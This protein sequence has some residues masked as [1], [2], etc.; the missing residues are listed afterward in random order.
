MTTLRV[1]TTSENRWGLAIVAGLPALLVALAVPL[2][3]DGALAGFAVA[4]LVA[5]VIIAAAAFGALAGVATVVAAVGLAALAANIAGFPVVPL[6]VVTAVLSVSA[7]AA[8]ILT[9][10]RWPGAAAIPGAIVIGIALASGLAA[11]LE[12]RLIASLAAVAIVLLAFLAGPWALRDAV[13]TTRGGEATALLMLIV[14]G[15]VTYLASTALD[16]RLGTPLRL[17]WLGISDPAVT[18]DGTLPDPFFIAARWQLDPTESPRPLFTVVAGEQAPLNRPV[19]ASFPR[20]N[21]FGWFNIE[22]PGQPGDDL[23][24]PLEPDWVSGRTRVDIG[25]AL[26]GQWVPAPQQV[27]QVL[28]S[29]ATRVET[30][31][32]VITAL[33]APVSQSFGISYAVP[34]ATDEQLQQARPQVLPDIDAA[35]LLP[36]GLPDDLQRIADR[37]A[38]EAGPATWDRLLALSEFFRSPRF[39]QAPPTAL[40]AGPPDRTYA[41]VAAAINARSGLQEEYAAAWALIARSWGVPTRLVIGWLPPNQDGF[42]DADASTDGGGEPVEVIVRGGDTSVWAQARLAGLGWVSYQPSPHD[43]SANRPAV[44]RPLNPEDLP[45]PTPTPDGDDTASDG[46]GANGGGGDGGAEDNS[47]AD[48]D[49]ASPLSTLATVAVVIAGVVA[50]VLA[51]VALWM[52][53]ATRMRRRRRQRWAAQEPAESAAAAVAW[54]RGVLAEADLPLPQAWAPAPHPLDVPEHPPQIAAPV[55]DFARAAAPIRFA[56]DAVTAEQAGDLWHRVAAIE[57][58]VAQSGGRR[59][60]WRRHTHPTPRS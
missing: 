42:T 52:V 46:G 15:V 19:W 9:R 1:G 27:S 30:E 48:G 60:W 36:G 11:T 50:V 34:T 10:G 47:D 26:P 55:A 3:V 7:L 25:V 38:D 22:A 31:S 24:R 39:V 8:W 21:G 18:P 57:A 28:G 32:D 29:M 35:V 14:V 40:A 54:L 49:G 33:S 41:G 20:Y 58:L 53:I 56:P 17:S 59:T 6:M 51:V 2:V 12:G 16:D 23:K 5:M 4:P 44:V 43:R 45:T 13:R 37:V